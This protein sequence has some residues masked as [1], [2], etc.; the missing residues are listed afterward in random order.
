MVARRPEA[1]REGLKMKP[2][3][4]RVHLRNLFDV[5]GE[6]DYQNSEIV[7]TFRGGLSGVD[8]KEVVLHVKIWVLPYI[9]GAMKM[10]YRSM[11]AE[12]DKFEESVSSGV[13]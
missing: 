13:E 6:Y 9:V 10:G 3:I 4:D 12:L 5:S 8:Y 1:N 2:K 7:L 11:K